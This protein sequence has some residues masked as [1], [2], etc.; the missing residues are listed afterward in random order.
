MNDEWGGWPSGFREQ[1]MRKEAEAPLAE[2][3]RSGD[4]RRAEGAP[5]VF[6]GEE[7]RGWVA[8]QVAE[9][10]RIRAQQV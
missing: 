5:R 2:V 8:P 3:C 10:Q 4:W 1:K 7:L 6:P 9:A